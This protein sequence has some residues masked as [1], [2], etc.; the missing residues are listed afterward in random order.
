M[1]LNM[2][3]VSTHFAANKRLRKK[4]KNA[5]EGEMFGTHLNATDTP[6]G[7]RPKARVQRYQP[8]KSIDAALAWQTG[9][10]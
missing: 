5:R 6:V 2:T 8:K 7:T 10:G 9:L 3:G 4:R 1:P